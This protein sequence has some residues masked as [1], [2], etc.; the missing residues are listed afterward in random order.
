LKKHCKI[1]LAKTKWLEILSDSHAACNTLKSENQV[2]IAKVKFLENEISESKNH[3]NFFS[4]GKLNKMMHDQK[5]SFDKSGLGFV[6]NCSSM[7]SISDLKNACAKKV[8]FVPTS[9]DKGKKVMVDP[10][11]SKPKS[12]IVHPPRKQHSQ[13]FVTTCHHYGKVGHTRPNCFKVKPRKHKNDSLYRR[14]SYE[15]LCN[16]MMVVLT[17]LDELEKSHKIS[18]SVKKTCIRKVD[19]IHLLREVVVDSPRV[20]WSH[21]MSMIIYHTYPRTCSVLW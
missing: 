17:R 1:E 16:M 11:V 19:T 20:R 10:Y 4:S 15:G 5:Y 9:S 2:L 18:L 13:R 21:G 7:S 6:D 14:N 3:L 12:R 8:M